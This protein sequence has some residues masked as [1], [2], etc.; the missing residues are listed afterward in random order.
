MTPHTETRFSE[1]VH[2]RA[3]HC[4]RRNFTLVELLVASAI[5]FVILGLALALLLHPYRVWE[6]MAAQFLLD[7]QLRMVRERMLH[8][9]EN[10]YGLLSASAASVQLQPGQTTNVEW[11]DFDVDPNQPPTPDQ[12]ND[13]V[14]CRVMV[15][16]GLGLTARTVPGSGRPVSLL[17]PNVKVN[18][19]DVQRNG[20]TLHVTLALQVRQGGKTYVRSTQFDVFLRNP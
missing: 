14:T 11:V 6:D 15:T 13:D 9:V 7:H 16:P 3:P 8:G 17:R 12:S 19:F 1:R 10:R 20:R 18:Q 5:G 2:L 4:R